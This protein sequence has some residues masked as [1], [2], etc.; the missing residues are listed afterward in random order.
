LRKVY[1]HSNAMIPPW[2]VLR[3]SPSEKACRILPRQNRSMTGLECLHSP[4][5]VLWIK[6][7]PDCTQTGMRARGALIP[8]EGQL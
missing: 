6:A 2:K 4:P 1:M 7:Y 5:Q 8:P 3:I